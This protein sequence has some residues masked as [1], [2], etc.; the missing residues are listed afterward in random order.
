MH[1]KYPREL[2]EAWCLVKG[3]L[4]RKMWSWRQGAFSVAMKLTLV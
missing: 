4:V 2:Q 1:F 3:K